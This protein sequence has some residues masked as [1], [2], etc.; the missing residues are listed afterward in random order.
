MRAA[1]H[2]QT[3]KASNWRTADEINKK[4]FRIVEAETVT[5]SVWCADHKLRSSHSCIDIQIE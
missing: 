1:L 2:S 3:E 4:L 5:G